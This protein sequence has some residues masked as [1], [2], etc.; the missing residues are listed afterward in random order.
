MMSLKIEFNQPKGL[1]TLECQDGENVLLNGPI[2]EV[3]TQHLEDALLFI[4]K[5][6]RITNGEQNPDSEL[7]GWK[8]FAEIMI[9]KEN[10]NQLTMSNAELIK[11][12]HQ[13]SVND[14]KSFNRKITHL[15][16]GLFAG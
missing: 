6:L 11:K 14:L 15:L 8:D 5:I 9:T 12:R 2:E 10:Y 16:K 1:V 4:V 3:N 13:E 7:T